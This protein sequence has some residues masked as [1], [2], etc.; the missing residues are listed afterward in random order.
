MYRTLI[1]L[2]VVTTLVGLSTAARAADELVDNPPFVHWS[3]FKVGTTVTQRETV[4]FAQESFEGDYYP[5]G[6]HEKDLTYT[7]IEVTPKKVVV[8]LIVSEYGRGSIIEQAPLKITYVPKVKKEHV[9]TSKEGIETFKE[10][11]EDVKVLGKTFHCE[12]VETID[13]E[14]G[15]TT[16]RK[17][18]TAKDIPGGT[19]KEVRSTK[20]GK[21]VLNEA[22][23]T[24]VQYD[25][26]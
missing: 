18:W 12:W 14:D 3:A 2:A 22:F 24:V 5:E 16:Y 25:A 1:P 19:V 9:S 23:F 4:K 13:E 10:G 26:K 17:Q 11:E 6:T 20:K 8:R 21:E 7:L 15:V